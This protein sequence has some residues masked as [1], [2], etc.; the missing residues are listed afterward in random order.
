MPGLVLLSLFLG[1][2]ITTRVL[3]MSE[4]LRSSCNAAHKQN[5][6]DRKKGMTATGCW[7]FR[8]PVGEPEEDVGIDSLLPQSKASETEGRFRSSSVRCEMSSLFR[9]GEQ[10]LCLLG[11]SQPW[12]EC[13]PW[14][15]TDS[16]EHTFERTS[17]A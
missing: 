13:P 11:G 12:A 6:P 5:H 9:A 14:L 15:L 16:R 2:T 4:L 1:E 10:M 8:K 3:Q 7:P 17:Q